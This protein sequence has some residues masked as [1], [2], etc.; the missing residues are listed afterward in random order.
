M[1]SVEALQVGL[2]LLDILN[3]LAS[4][5]TTKLVREKK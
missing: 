2:E 1:N 5:I 3:K 4:I